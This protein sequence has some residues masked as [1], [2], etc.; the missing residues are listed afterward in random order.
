MKTCPV[1]NQRT[2]SLDDCIDLC[3][4][5]N[6]QDETQIKSGS[7]LKCNTVC[8]WNGNNAYPGECYGYTTT[9]NT[10]DVSV[11][12]ANPICDTGTWLNPTF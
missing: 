5:Y 6:V 11:A 3:A 10:S 2:T 8:W 4:S 1:V 9:Q 12:I 7:K